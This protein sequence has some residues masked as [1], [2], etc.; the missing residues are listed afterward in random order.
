VWFKQQG[1]E[2]LFPICGS[3]KGRRKKIKD[4]LVLASRS[5]GQREEKMVKKKREEGTANLSKR[6]V[7]CYDYFQ[8][9]RLFAGFTKARRRKRQNSYWAS[10]NNVHYYSTHIQPQIQE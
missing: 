9:Y 2:G 3:G 6:C 10:S 7:T 4:F 8:S 1:K 5:V